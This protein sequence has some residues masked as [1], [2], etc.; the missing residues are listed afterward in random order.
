MSNPSMVRSI[1]VLTVF[2]AALA[3]YLVQVS[4]LGSIAAF[5][6]AAVSLIV[7]LLRP[8]VGGASD[9]KATSRSAESVPAQVDS[10]EVRRSQEEATTRA[11]LVAAKDS[12][13]KIH[14]ELKI[15]AD[16][17]SL[18]VSRT[19]FLR[20]LLRLVTNKS[21][22]A[23][24]DLMERFMAVSGELGSVLSRAETV[25][26]QVD[27]SAGGSV[28]AV[29]DEARSASRAE[30]EVLRTFIAG[31]KDTAKSTERMRELVEGSMEML[32]D[33]EDVSER[34]RLIAFNLAV[35]AARIGRQGQGI[36]VIVN[37]L[38]S[39]NDKIIAF[40]KAVA[41][42]L[43]ENR[44]LGVRIA[45]RLG[46]E[47]GALA[48]KVENGRIASERTL[49]RLI[50]TTKSVVD[51]LDTMTSSFNAARQSMDGMLTSMQFQDITRQQVETVDWALA[52]TTEELG[53]ILAAKGHHEP[54]DRNVVE[55]FR[56]RL[57]K[58]AKVQDEKAL[59]L[60]VKV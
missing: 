14:G 47:T 45:D 55:D 59:I 30:A 12:L 6:F 15:L 3:G 1:Q 48:D 46:K 13:D 5:V 4:P 9:G 19:P 32:R 25:R 42:R 2:S 7:L 27:G 58:Q 41:I 44:D 21:E 26:S 43:K 29:V 49:E 39:I 60:E 11:E 53:R 57:E 18:A 50:G 28:S 34:S 17:I 20:A 24:F 16:G 54:L 35:E 40:S 38:S 36:K 52:D 56:R 51:L 33:I 10:S 23:V 22:E 8:A 31:S 37:E